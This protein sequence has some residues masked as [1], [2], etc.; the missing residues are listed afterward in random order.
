M[1]ENTELRSYTL[2]TGDDGEVQLV[3][4]T[5]SLERHGLPN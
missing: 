3:E 1:W 2:E 5:E 4:E